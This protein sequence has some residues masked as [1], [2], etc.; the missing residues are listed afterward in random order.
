MPA[1]PVAVRCGETRKRLRKGAW[2][3][4]RKVGWKVALDSDGSSAC[5]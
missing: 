1:T 2:W 5:G 4:M 3:M